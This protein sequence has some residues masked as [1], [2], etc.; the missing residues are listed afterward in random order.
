MKFQFFNAILSTLHS[1]SR[2]GKNNIFSAKTTFMCVFILVAM[3]YVLNVQHV[4][5]TIKPIL[6]LDSCA[7]H[8]I[9]DI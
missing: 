1:N 6:A 7:F 5:R 9:T 4:Q 3:L 8:I 2:F